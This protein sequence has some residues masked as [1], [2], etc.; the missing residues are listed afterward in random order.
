MSL[1]AVNWGKG[2]APCIGNNVL[3]GA[4]AVVL[5]DI[6]IGNN[7]IIGANAVVLNDIPANSYAVG[8]PVKIRRRKV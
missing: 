3:I 2:E 4:G 8:I 1:L 7:V 6:S 5:G